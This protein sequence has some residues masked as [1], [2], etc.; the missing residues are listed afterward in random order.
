MLSAVHRTFGDGIAH[1]S[2]DN[3]LRKSEMTPPVVNLA[4]R[5][6]PEPKPHNA[7]EHHAE[8]HK[9]AHVE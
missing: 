5:P 8:Q 6:Q 9:H 3:S 7:G 1:N 4:A 2:R